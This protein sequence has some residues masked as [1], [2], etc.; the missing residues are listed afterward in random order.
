[1]T[2]LTQPQSNLFI[3][4]E[5]AEIPVQTESFDNAQNEINRNT[6]PFSDLRSGKFRRLFNR[7][8]IIR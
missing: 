2:T 3:D 5:G 6:Q 7:H 4:R 1:M 8:S